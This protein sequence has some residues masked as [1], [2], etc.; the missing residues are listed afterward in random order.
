MAQD[1]R[2]TC[3]ICSVVSLLRKHWNETGYCVKGTEE[4]VACVWLFKD[5]CSGEARLDLWPVAFPQQASRG[6]GRCVEGPAA[7]VDCCP[8]LPLR[9]PVGALKPTPVGELR[10][11]GHSLGHNHVVCLLQLLISHPKSAA[12]IG[13]SRRVR[14]ISKPSYPSGAVCSGGS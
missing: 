11:W 5:A 4:G 14:H 10:P 8:F 2:P 1:S 7:P 6:S 13:Y 9:W 12:A 3:W